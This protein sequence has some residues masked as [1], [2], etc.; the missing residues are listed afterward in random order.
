[1]SK[2]TK[3]ELA[4]IEARMRAL[5]DPD[6]SDPDNPEWTAV[7]FARAVAVDDAPSGE[8]EMIF[9]AFPKTQRRRGPNKTPAKRL[10]S[11]RLSERVLEHFRAQGEGWQSRIN[12]ALE[13]VVDRDQRK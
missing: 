6:L 7:D 3:A 11:L 9:A 1:M 2:P 8:R 4:E 10:T 12:Q 5:P 13:A